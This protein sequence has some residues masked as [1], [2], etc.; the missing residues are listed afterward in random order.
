[1]PDPVELTVRCTNARGECCKVHGVFNGAC[2]EALGV[3]KKREKYLDCESRRITTLR[4]NDVRRK[5]QA[6]RYMAFLQA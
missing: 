5:M 4:R 6:T 1:M 2:K 3:E